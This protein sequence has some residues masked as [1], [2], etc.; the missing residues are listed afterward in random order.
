MNESEEL[1]QKA[2]DGDIASWGS[3]MTHPL[4]R[5][6]GHRARLDRRVQGRIDAADVVQEIY[7]EAWRHLPAYLGNPTMPFYLWLRGLTGHKISELH[8][9][10]LGAQMRDAKREI[11]LTTASRETSALRLGRIDF[12]AAYRSPG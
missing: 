4:E 10:H 8:R 12:G 3:V 7:L 11:S 5:L 6:S 2:A 1:L 9:Q